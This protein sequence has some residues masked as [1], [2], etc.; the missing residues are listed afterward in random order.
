MEIVEKSQVAPSAT[1]SVNAAALKKRAAG[2]KVYNL[3]A[4]EAFIDTPSVIRDAALRAVEQGHTYYTPSAGIPELRE[5]A[6]M[7]MNEEFNCSYAR[8]NVCVT[9]GGK[10]GLYLLFQALLNSGDEV[11]VPSPYWVSYPKMIDL[12]G[13][14]PVVVKT[15]YDNGWKLSV[16]ELEKKVSP[17]TKILIFNNGSNPTGVLYSRDEVRDILNWAGSHNIIVIADEVYAKLVYDDTSY[18]SC[19]AFKD[20]VSHVVVVQSTSKMFSMT[21]WRVGFVFAPQHIVSG[22]SALQGQSTS[23]ASSVAQWSSV[24]AFAHADQIT[25]FVRQQM[26]QRRDTLIH[27]LQEHFG[28]DVPK[29]SSALYLFT[30]L[31]TFGISEM[32]DIAFCKRAIE[33]AGVAFVPGSA[34]GAPGFVRMSFGIAPEDIRVGVQVL[35]EYVSLDR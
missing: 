12:F 35:H 14:K 10:F 28:V 9:N 4:G 5:V 34:F 30:P 3:S 24:S 27:A 31:R 33:D 19:G 15:T 6:S 18:P 2:Q 20:H 25:T 26:K 1:L 22:L 29:P 13:G 8:E 32:D 17:K 7:W 11:L 16:S 21:G 23:G